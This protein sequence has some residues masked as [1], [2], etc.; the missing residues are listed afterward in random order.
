MSVVT[1]D[2]SPD[3]LLAAIYT[4]TEGVPV[5]VAEVVRLLPEETSLAAA[6]RSGGEIVTAAM[7]EAVEA[8]LVTPT[9]DA[10]LVFSH[11]LI[12]QSIREEMPLARR[13][14]LHQRG[15]PYG[16]AGPKATILDSEAK[17]MET[18]SYKRGQAICK[19]NADGAEMYLILSGVV[20]VFKTINSERI[21]LAVLKKGD[22][23]GEMCPLLGHK[24]SATVVADESSEVLSLSQEGLMRKFQESPEFGL[25]MAQTLAKR[26]EHAHEIIS[27]LAGEKTSLEVIHGS[28]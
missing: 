20:R 15:A 25:K 22:F 2:D 5:F 18:L 6:E 13:V 14:E 17:T 3:A 21:E 4:A 24:R 28:R 9:D 11:A 7:E 1:G 26:L 27:Q 12:Q 23:F 10:N 19:E 16:D 8:E